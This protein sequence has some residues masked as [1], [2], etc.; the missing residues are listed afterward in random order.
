MSDYNES[1]DYTFGDPISIDGKKWLTIAEYA[2]KVKDYPH[3]D[4]CSYS[5]ADGPYKDLICG[6]FAV[7]I[8]KLEVGIDTSKFRCA[9][10]RDIS[11]L[12]VVSETNL[13]TLNKSLQVLTCVVLTSSPGNKTVLEESSTEV[14]ITTNKFLLGYDNDSPS[15]MLSG[16]DANTPSSSYSAE[17]ESLFLTP[18]SKSQVKPS[19]QIEIEETS[20]PINTIEGEEK[21]P[22][23]RGTRGNFSLPRGE[24]SPSASPKRKSS[25]EE[26][27]S[28]RKRSPSPFAGE[29][30]VSEFHREDNLPDK[31]KLSSLSPR[32]VLVRLRELEKSLSPRETTFQ[33]GRKYSS[34]TTT[35]K[36]SHFQFRNRTQDDLSNIVD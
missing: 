1:K 33:T 9:V 2:T 10:C 17:D 21:P 29:R 22:L 26:D 7:S 35:K 15:S 27:K 11:N 20:T 8:G 36:K 32:S 34:N 28:P 6:A 19:F 25:E 13:S 3:F 14:K 23:T 30:L 24:R 31:V 4:F 16:E 5:P 12:E 18:S